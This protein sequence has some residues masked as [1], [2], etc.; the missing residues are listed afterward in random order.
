MKIPDPRKH[1]NP[2]GTYN[3][4][5]Y[6]SEMSGLSQAE[7]KWMWERQKVLRDTGH[8]VAE[9][10]AIIKEEARSRPWEQAKP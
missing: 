10:K 4:V 8:T 1:R 5:T 2:D 3:G 7:I 9:I 6:M